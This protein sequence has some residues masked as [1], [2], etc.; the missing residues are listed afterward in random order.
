MLKGIATQGELA[1]FQDILDRMTTNLWFHVNETQ[2]G[3]PLG[4]SLSQAHGIDLIV[5]TTDADGNDVSEYQDNNGDR[6]SD[7]S[8]S[9]K[10]NFVRFV[11]D[12]VPYYAPLQTTTDAGQAAGTGALSSTDPSADMPGGSA[13]ITDYATIESQAAENLDSLLR[14]HAQLPAQRAH[15]PLTV[16]A[17]PTLDSAGHTV[18]THL[19]KL[20]YNNIVYS[21]PA[22]DRLGGPVQGVRGLS[23]PTCTFDGATHGHYGLS[24]CTLNMN[25]KAGASWPGHVSLHYTFTTGTL[26]ITY[27]WEYYISSWEPQVVGSK[28]D[29][30]GHGGLTPLS[31]ISG[32]IT[33]LPTTLDSTWTIDPPGGDDNN[34]FK[35]RIKLTNSQGTTYGCEIT[36]YIKDHAACCWFCT[37]SNKTQRISEEQWATV[38]LIEKDLF[39]KCPRMVAWYLSYGD[40]LVGRMLHN[41]VPQSWFEEFTVDLLGV[42]KGKGLDAAARFYVEQVGQA[43]AWHWSE[44]AYR[45]YQAGKAWLAK[46]A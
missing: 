6:V 24:G 31:G 32:T 1:T 3:Q 37:Q 20:Q 36:V 18:G 8:A 40:D 27:L 9:G 35:M 34:T 10:A 29:S 21:I 4:S 19:I 30:T 15:L 26:P 46:L 7:A 13:L 28:I 44:C 25:T 38:G 12:G 5:G 2:V 33:S 22:C 43:T 14:E 39:R 45:G 42:Y 41:G 23:C 11:I 17:T 16:I